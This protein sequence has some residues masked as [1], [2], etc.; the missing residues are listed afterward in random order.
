MGIR[1]QNRNNGKLLAGMLMHFLVENMVR[2]P[3][4]MS[5]WV[6][7]TL[8]VGVEPVQASDE[9]AGS[10]S[11]PL[12]ATPEFVEASLPESSQPVP[13]I[14]PL[15][16]LEPPATTVED[17][18]AQIA[19]SL[20]QITDVRVETTEAS[21]Q[22]VL[23]T[24]NGELSVPVTRSLGNALVADIPNAVLA[25]PS[26]EEFQQDNPIAGIA[27][28]SVTNLPGVGGAS[29]AENQ[30]RVAITGIDAP[31]TAD[32]RGASQELVLNVMP[33]TETVDSNGEAIQVVVTG[34]DEESYAVP[35]ASI[36]TRTDIPLRD[37]PFSV[38]VIPEQVLEDRQ[39]R[40]VTDVIQ[41]IPGVNLVQPPQFVSEEF[42]T[43]RGF[44]SV[45]TVNGLRDTTTDTTGSAIANIERIEVLRGPAGALFGQG[46]PGGTVNIVTERP[47]DEPFYE[48]TGSVG[49]FNTYEGSVDL[50][51]PLTSDESLLYRFTASA[52]QLGNDGVAPA[53]ERYFVSPVLTWRISDDTQIT[54]ETEFVST[55]SPDSF[56][57]PARGTVLPN[58]SGDIPLDRYIGEP[59]ERFFDQN[60]RQV[61]RVGYN[62]EH[63]FNDNWR[64]RNA[65]RAS[66]QQFE[67]NGIFGFDLSEDGRTLTRGGGFSNAYRN[68]Y[69]LDTNLVGEFATGSIEHQ[70]LFG[71]DLSTDFFEVDFGSVAIAPLDLFDPVYG[72]QNIG[73]VTGGFPSFTQTIDRLGIYLQDQIT[74]R[75]D[76]RMLLGGRFD[77]IRQET[78]DGTTTNS[79]QD[80][81]FS[82]RVGLVYQPS[83]T[84]SLYASYSRSFEQV[85]G[86]N[87]D[88]ELFEPERGTQYEVGVKADWLEGNLSTTLAFFDITRSNV[89]TADPND[90]NFSIQ[91]GEQR[92]RGVEFNVAGE[93]LPGWN[94]IGG[95]AYTDARITEDNTLE[96]GNFISG[97]PENSVSLWTTYKIQSGSLE[98][99]GFGLGLFYVGERQGDANNSFTL[100]DYLRTDAAL[101]YRRDQFRAALNVRN[102]FN[103]DYFEGTFGDDFT[104]LPGFSR[105]VQFTIGWQF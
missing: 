3:V 65:V 45:T 73:A 37:L 59:T 79:Q 40:S 94:I 41:T 9:I 57:L 52:S 1:L 34:E 67:E 30:V 50:T 16:E 10:Q 20:V 92:S 53:S 29:P 71:V 43:I 42:F 51:G 24:A 14:A 78:D 89:L 18:L 96:E 56:G 90:A 47:E 23:E 62:L 32:I 98:G 64:L 7:S 104:V 31:P 103:V 95:Y 38:Q 72:S 77:L 60:D 66:F 105:T 48:I 55:W 17:W 28:V 81:A 99:L 36:G 12:D 93:I 63:R 5:L 25:L 35:G 70:V 88:Q 22:V 101:F 33:G 26:G 75:P 97:V 15:N 100:P 8:A 21:L 19:Q 69:L 4:L 61:W 83:D 102:L 49:S 82:P 91:T 39:A 46:A 6:L 54:F 13:P 58:P 74:L 84:V 85:T 76:L 2:L 80:E 87:F 11:V 44:N 27:L 68:V 86:T